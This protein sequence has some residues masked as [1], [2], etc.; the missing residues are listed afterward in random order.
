MINLTYD[1]LSWD[2]SQS[3]DDDG[4]NGV[5]SFCIEYDTVAIDGRH[6][7][8]QLQIFS[9]QVQFITFSPL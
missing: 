3:A 1:E 5:D 7:A 9:P 2:Y 8:K 4:D 6:I